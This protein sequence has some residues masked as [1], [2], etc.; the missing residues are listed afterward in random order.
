MVEMTAVQPHIT[1]TPAL[2]DIL[3]IVMSLLTWHH[4]WLQSFWHLGSHTQVFAKSVE[5]QLQELPSCCNDCSAQLAH[6]VDVAVPQSNAAAYNYRRCVAVNNGDGSQSNTDH[7]DASLVWV[8]IQ[9]HDL[10]Y[11]V[12]DVTLQSGH[13]AIGG[14]TWIKSDTCAAIP[15]QG[16]IM[17]ITVAPAQLLRWVIRSFSTYADVWQCISQ[18]LQRTII[19]GVLG[20]MIEMTASQPHTTHMLAMKIIYNIMTLFADFAS[21]LVA[22]RHLCSHTHVIAKSAK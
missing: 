9:Y 1:H 17:Q 2:D 10:Y 21:P 16:Q 11:L 15:R 8:V 5:K 19:Q 12:H 18:M 3:N 4:L 7:P 20:S 13:I 6:C 14:D 22:M